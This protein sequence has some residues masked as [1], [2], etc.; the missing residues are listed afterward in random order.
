MREFALES[1][2]A[3][4]GQLKVTGKGKPIHNVS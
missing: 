4:V 1:L 2:E 3:A